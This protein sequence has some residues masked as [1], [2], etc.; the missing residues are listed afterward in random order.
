MKDISEMTDQ[1][2]E[3]YLLKMTIEA[4][5]VRKSKSSTYNPNVTVR[6]P[7]ILREEAIKAANERGI[8]LTYLIIDGIVTALTKYRKE[9]H[10]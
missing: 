8:T 1:E 5:A 10:Q 7:A 6:L 4:E 2:Y 9:A 3:I